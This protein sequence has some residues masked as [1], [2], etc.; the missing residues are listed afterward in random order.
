MGVLAGQGLSGAYRGL[1][2]LTAYLRPPPPGSPISRGPVSE[3]RGPQR[4]GLRVVPQPQPCLA[5]DLDAQA[6]V[7]HPSG[8][9]NGP[10][11]A[12]GCPQG[13]QGEDR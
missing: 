6:A 10:T 5:D 4:N 3:Q 9:G 7:R 13:H 1:T 11:A 2:W 12:S 8:P